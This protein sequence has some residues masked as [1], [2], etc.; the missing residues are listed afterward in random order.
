[1]CWWFSEAS[2]PDLVLASVFCG[3]AL[4]LSFAPSQG[5][6]CDFDLVSISELLHLDMLAAVTTSS[7]AASYLAKA[8][9]SFLQAAVSASPAQMASHTPA[10]TEGQH[11]YSP[12]VQMPRTALAKAT[13]TAVHP[14][15]K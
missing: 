11:V 10:P 8:L 9:R 13:V 7:A 1:M 2:L 3:A 4:P 6:C 14:V 5:M 15:H 12:A